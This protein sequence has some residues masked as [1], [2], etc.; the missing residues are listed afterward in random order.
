MKHTTVIS[1][2]VGFLLSLI[3]TFT[4]YIVVVNHVVQLGILTAVILTLALIQLTIQ[5]VFFL[6]LGNEEKPYWN[7]MFFI[8]TAGII[9]IIVVGA[10][11]IMSHLNYNM[12]PQSMDTTIMKNEGMHY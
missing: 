8:S 10:V 5:L 3:C 9:F 11:W 7:S 2:I 1:Y 6:H 12:S 4:A